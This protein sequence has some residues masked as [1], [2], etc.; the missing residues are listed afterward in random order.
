MPGHTERQFVFA[1]EH[2]TGPVLPEQFRFFVGMST[3]NRFNA[4]LEHASDFEHFARPEYIR[5]G[6][7]QHVRPCDMRLNDHR[8][9][10]GVPGYRR[11][12]TLAERLHDFTILLGNDD[13]NAARD[14]CFT[15]A[16][17]DATVAHDHDMTGKAMQV[18]CH[19]EFRQRVI[20]A[21]Q[22]A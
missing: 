4:W 19:R 6:D 20:R 8:R 13:G 15:N 16:L 17:A 21:L 3:Y 7:H 22:R 2:L 12:T 9:I 5:D 11:Y 1:H 14:Q 10:G 18:D